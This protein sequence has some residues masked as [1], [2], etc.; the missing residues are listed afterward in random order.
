MAAEFTKYK[1]NYFPNKY[2]NVQRTNVF[3]VIS[4]EHVSNAFAHNVHHQALLG[5]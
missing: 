5:R 2:E 4:I 3:D 1:R